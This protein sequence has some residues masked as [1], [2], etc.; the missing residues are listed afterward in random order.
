MSIFHSILIFLPPSDLLK[1]KEIFNF[2]VIVLLGRPQKLPSVHVI[3]ILS[4]A[5]VVREE[6]FAFSLDRVHY[7]KNP[8]SRHRARYIR[9]HLVFVILLLWLGPMDFHNASIYYKYVYPVDFHSMGLLLS[10]LLLHS[11]NY[12][13]IICIITKSKITPQ[14]FTG[15]T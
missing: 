11:S 14:D 5:D 2:V 12:I 7:D 10:L 9:Y 4:L 15:A 3:S 13:I 1:F 8:E 6:C